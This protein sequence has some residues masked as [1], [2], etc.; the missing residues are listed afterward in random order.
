[1][2]LM[3]DIKVKYFQNFVSVNIRPIAEEGWYFV[4]RIV[5]FSAREIWAKEGS[6]KIIF[7]ISNFTERRSVSMV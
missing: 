3:K 2:G 6:A 1:M 5:Q 7:Q 4:W